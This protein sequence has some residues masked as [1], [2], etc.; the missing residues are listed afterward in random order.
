MGFNKDIKRPT[1]TKTRFLSRRR[2][3]EGE[4]NTKKQKQKQANKKFGR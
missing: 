1:A 2:K 3:Q 4:N